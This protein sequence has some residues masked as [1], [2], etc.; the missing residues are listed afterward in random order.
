MNI[1]CTLINKDIS[2]TLPHYSREGDGAVDVYA[3]AITNEKGYFH[4]YIEYGTNLAFEIPEGYGAFLLPRSSVSNKNLILSNSIGLVD[5]NYR[6]EVKWRF[7][8]KWGYE[9]YNIGDRIGQMIVLPLPKLEFEL[10]DVL[11]NTNR[12]AGAYGSSGV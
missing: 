4:E 2:T 10:V 5:S 9:Q 8:K 1:K 7:Y 11:S 3:T 6:G 12:G